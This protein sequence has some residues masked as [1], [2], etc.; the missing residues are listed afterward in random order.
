MVFVIKNSRI[1]AIA[2][3]DCIIH[4]D[5]DSGRTEFAH[6]TVDWLVQNPV[7]PYSWKM[8]IPDNEAHVFNGRLHVYGSLDA[9]G[10]YCSPYIVP[11]MTGDLK[12]WSS[13]GLAF[14]S[15][16]G[17]SVFKGR[18]LWGSDVHYYKGKYLLYGAYE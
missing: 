13:D 2:D 14:S 15:F 11:V 1:Q 9:S 18:N 3:G 7:L 8:Y 16:D 12:R 4:A 17:G 6:V 10:V 5:A